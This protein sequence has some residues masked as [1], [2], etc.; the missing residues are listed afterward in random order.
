MKN[1]PL[2]YCITLLWTTVANG[3]VYFVTDFDEK[4]ATHI[5]QAAF[6]APYDTVFVPYM[7]KDWIIRP[8]VINASHKTIIFGSGVVV[9]AKTGAFG[10]YDK[11]FEIIEQQNLTIIGY[12]ATWRMRKEEYL[13]GEWRHALSIVRCENISIYGLTIRDS[14]GDGIKIGRGRGGQPAYSKNIH[15]RDCILDNN[16]RQAISV[17]SVDTLL[18]ENCVLRNTNGTAP[19]AGIDFEPNNSDER[20]RAITIRNVDSYGNKGYGIQFLLPRL[21]SSSMAISA[22][23]QN[24]RVWGN[25]RGGVMVKSIGDKGVNGTITFDGC[26]VRDNLGN[27]FTIQ[28]KSKLAARVNITNCHIYNSDDYPIHLWGPA[29]QLGGIRFKNSYIVDNVDRP[30]LF[31]QGGSSIFDI[32]G[33]VI[34]NNPFGG[35]MSIGNGSSNVTVQDSIETDITTFVAIPD[36]NPRGGY[37]TTPITVSLSTETESTEIYY[38]IDGSE[39]TKNSLKYAAP[40]TLSQSALLKIQAYKDSRKSSIMRATFSISRGEIPPKPPEKLKVPE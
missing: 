11:L 14:G 16:R 29:V 12:G 32:T 21:N 39:P 37:F 17:I 3:S 22:V 26:I 30:F 36:I 4:D 40:L 13:T 5:L 19:Q 7:G 10:R 27:S 24:C 28:Q 23:I 34:V 20:L 1:L 15:I 6:E 38:T 31:V 9:S 33:N 2:F 8:V 25:I 18:I 35:Y